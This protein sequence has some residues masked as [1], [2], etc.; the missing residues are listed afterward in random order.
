MKIAR[1]VGTVVWVFAIVVL[2]VATEFD[3]WRGGLLPAPVLYLAAAI[4]A[5]GAWPIVRELGRAHQAGRRRVAE[6][7]R[8]LRARVDNPLPPGGVSE[9]PSRVT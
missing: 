8:A 5:I 2:A 4:G 3:I 7:E 1:V 9:S 6:R